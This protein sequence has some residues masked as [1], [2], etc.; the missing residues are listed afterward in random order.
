MPEEENNIIKKH[1]HEIGNEWIIPLMQK[2][3]VVD[4]KIKKWS[5]TTKLNADD[6]GLTNYDE[7]TKAFQEKY[8][9]LGQ[10]RLFPP[11][12][13][14]NINYIASRGRKNL[15]D[16]SFETLWGNFVPIDAF[17]EWEEENK[18]IKNDFKEA[19]KT[20]G[21]D[22]YKILQQ[23]SDD[24]SKIAYDVWHRLNP[25]VRQPPKA[26]VDEY[27]SKQIAKIPDVVDLMMLFNY[28]E[29]YYSITLPGIME[30]Q[31]T[32]V[33]EERQNQEFMSEKLRLRT[34]AE[35]RINEIFVEK[36]Q[37]MIDSFLK[38]TVYS[39]RKYIHK[40]CDEVL[41]SIG[42]KD[43][44]VN[45]NHKQ[46]ISNML[47]KVENLNFC[48]DE[49]IEE[50]LLDLKK[51]VLKPNNELVEENI[52]VKLTNI[53]KKVKDTINENFNENI[54]FTEI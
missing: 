33:E 38:D 12:A 42:K 1:S 32:I 10:E 37:D 44:K 50:M 7:S 48:H 4:L 3:L 49:E 46:K 39:L 13:L 24:Y 16:H 2:G 14:S 21:D 20:L 29:V 11:E 25:N 9:N 53:S 15:R 27:V 51:D 30:K 8:I 54:E 43:N 35:R 18:N 23:V 26:F 19:V 40:I 17:L 6:L 31:I 47:K 5:G 22:Y 34:E 52:I 41:L 45:K 36:R 28:Q